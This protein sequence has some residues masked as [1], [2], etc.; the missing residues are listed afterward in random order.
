MSPVP[1]GADEMDATVSTADVR[2]LAGRPWERRRQ[3]GS[4]GP[5]GAPRHRGCPDDQRSYEKRHLRASA[6]HSAHSCE[7]PL[8]RCSPPQL[9]RGCELADGSTV[10]VLQRALGRSGFQLDAAP[11]QPRPTNPEPRSASWSTAPCSMTVPPLGCSSSHLPRRCG[12]AGWPVIGPPALADRCGQGSRPLGTCRLR[13]G[14]C[15]C[16]SARGAARAPSRPGRRA[17]A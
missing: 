10:V 12:A 3:Y 1:S 16:S 17:P 8:R 13:N 9:S 15:T 14:R 6:H 4:S 2:D 11:R 5:H 7:V